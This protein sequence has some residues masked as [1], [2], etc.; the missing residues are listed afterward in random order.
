LNLEAKRTE[1]LK[2]CNEWSESAEEKF[3][4]IRIDLEETWKQI[5]DVMKN[6]ISKV[7]NHLKSE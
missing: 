2:N 3:S 6:G 4:L 5:S 1:L 7:K